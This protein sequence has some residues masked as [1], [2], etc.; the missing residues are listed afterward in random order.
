[1]VFSNNYD[2]QPL[3]NSVG[4]LAAVQRTAISADTQILDAA[5]VHALA[6]LKGF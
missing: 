5:F 1:M 4:H 6:A 2:C 3:L